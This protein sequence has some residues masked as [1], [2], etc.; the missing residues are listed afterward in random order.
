[1]IKFP[2]VNKFPRLG[3]FLAMPYRNTTFVALGDD[4]QQCKNQT[5]MGIGTS[6]MHGDLKVIVFKTCLRSAKEKGL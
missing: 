3:N 2:R 5:D 4:F 1:M 6:P